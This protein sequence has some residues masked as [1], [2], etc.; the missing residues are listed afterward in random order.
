MKRRNRK[1]MFIII[2]FLI[3]LIGILMIFFNIPY[4]KTKTEFEMSAKNMIAAF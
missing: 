4:S 2:G 1:T 3:S